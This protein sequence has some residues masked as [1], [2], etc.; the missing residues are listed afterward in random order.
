MFPKQTEKKTSLLDYNSILLNVLKTLKQGWARHSGWWVGAKGS[1]YVTSLCKQVRKI[2][3]KDHL[4][5]HFH[6]LSA[7]HHLRTK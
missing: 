4:I 6:L 5:S 2:V 3:K 7:N 1:T